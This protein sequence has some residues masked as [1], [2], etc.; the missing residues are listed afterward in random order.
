VQ[1]R[2]RRPI[3]GLD[4]RNF[5]LTEEGRVAGEQSFLGAA[6]RSD[7]SDISILLDRSPAALALRQDMDAAIRD[8]RAGP[9]RIVSLISAGEQPLRE[10]VEG[11]APSLAA[12][13][14]AARGSASSY[15]LRWR[16]DLGLRLAA[17]D[18]LNGAKK[19]AVVFVSSGGLGELAFEHYGLSELAAYLA[20]NGVIFYAVLLGNNPP[21]EEL[22][23]LCDQTGG[24]ILPLYRAQ[25]ITA[26]LSGLTAAPTGSYTLSYRSALPTNFGRAYLPV[27]AEVY[28][29][30]RSGRDATGYF[31][32]ME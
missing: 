2:R 19:R 17:T 20:N 25:G 8:I 29:M 21:A 4:A 23:Y 1:D 9:S 30:E 32:P 10:R 16:F 22:R 12:L 15:S 24:S 14:A 11:T 5:L 3:V 28:L 31:P 27:E 18:L 6:F 13:A 7:A 26:A